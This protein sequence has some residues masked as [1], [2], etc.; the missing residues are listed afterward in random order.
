[1]ILAVAI[2]AGA[3]VERGDTYEGAGRGLAIGGGDGAG[4]FATRTS[5][6]ADGVDAV[7]E[8]NGEIGFA[9][10]ANQGI[11]GFILT[12]HL[13]GVIAVELIGRVENFDAGLI[14]E[15]GE[16]GDGRLPG[17]VE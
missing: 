12:A 11:A 15:F 7:L 13:G 3:V 6:P 2:G 8:D 9:Q 5:E 14:R 17:N 16:R 1:L 4:E 10:Q